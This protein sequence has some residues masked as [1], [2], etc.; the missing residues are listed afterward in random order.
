MRF[1]IAL[2]LT[3][4]ASQAG[5]FYKC[6]DAHGQPVFSDRPCGGDAEDVSIEAPPESGS[7]APDDFSAVRASSAVR[8]AERQIEYLE[9]RIDRY[10]SERDSKLAKLKHDTYRANS[11]LAG[12]QYRESLATEM[13]SVNSEYSSKIAADR[14]KINRIQDKMERANSS[15]GPD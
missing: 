5:A 15:S 9:D 11:N 3:I 7:V 2:V 4:T 13:Q 6:T 1:V 14:E 12:A 8:D 10:E